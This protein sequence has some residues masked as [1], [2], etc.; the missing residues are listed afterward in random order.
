M[1]KRTETT[2]KAFHFDMSLILNLCDYL[3]VF[4]LVSDGV[5]PDW[6]LQTVWLL[7]YEWWT[8][9]SS[10]SLSNLVSGDKKKHFGFETFAV[11]LM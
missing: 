10:N 6:K 2:P 5:Q 3:Y 8:L 9:K 11:L 4:D 7:I 1:S